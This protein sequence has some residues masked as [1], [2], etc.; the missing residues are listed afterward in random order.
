MA[1]Q[2]IG[3]KTDAMYN[4]YRIVNEEDLREGMLQAEEYL[5]RHKSGHKADTEEKN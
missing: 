3:H 4:R 2:I 5:A 1:K